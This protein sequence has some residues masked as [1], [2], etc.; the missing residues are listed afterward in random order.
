MATSG[1]TEIADGNA[2]V[3]GYCAVV[4]CER[5]SPDRIPR[6]YR[7]LSDYCPVVVNLKNVDD[8]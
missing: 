1:M 8:D 3:T 5:L 7:E 2:R 6:A 4:D